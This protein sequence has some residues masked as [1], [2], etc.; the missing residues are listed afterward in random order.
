MHNHSDTHSA[1]WQ[2]LEV[3][4]RWILQ[5]GIMRERRERVA[6]A[7]LRPTETLMHACQRKLHVSVYET[8]QTIISW[9]LP[10]YK[11]LYDTHAQLTSVSYKH[12]KRSVRYV[13]IGIL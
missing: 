13:Y 4:F 1:E 11:G 9:L 6:Y 8:A 5:Y 10:A 7:S 3:I 12:A 2:D